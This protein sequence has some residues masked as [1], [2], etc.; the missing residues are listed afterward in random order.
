M[1]KNLTNNKI[2]TKDYKICK[3]IN[4]K[5]RGLM[6]SKQKNLVFEFDKEQIRSLHMFFVFFPID[7]LFLNERKEVVDLKEKFM[8]FSFYTSKV[9]AKYVLELKQ[10]S[11]KNSEIKLK[12]KIEF[13]DL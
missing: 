5:A 4:S 13:N 12:N 11:V 2:I 8:P 6:F 3:S 9:K 10:G 7:I 1:I